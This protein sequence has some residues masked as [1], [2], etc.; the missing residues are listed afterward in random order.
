M[1]ELYQVQV[2]WGRR[3]ATEFWSP[4]IGPFYTSDAAHQA[5]KDLRKALK[6]GKRKWQGRVHVSRMVD[7]ERAIK[8]C[9]RPDHAVYD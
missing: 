3:G 7:L 8:F 5:A 2:Y 6:K 1:A 9:S 4:P